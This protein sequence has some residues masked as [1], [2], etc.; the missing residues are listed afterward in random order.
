MTHGYVHIIWDLDDDE[1][2]NV[3]HISEHGLDKDE[4]EDVLLNVDNPTTESFSSGEPATF[5]YT[6]TGRHIVVVWEHVQDDPLT[7]RP[8]TAYAAP[9]PRTPKRK[10]R[11]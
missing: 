11:K 2:G 4:V 3:R 6:R 10:R 9:P 1:H 5:G 7:V 8:I